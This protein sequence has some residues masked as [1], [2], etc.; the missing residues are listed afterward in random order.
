MS[1]N[2]IESADEGFD[3][4]ERLKNERKFMLEY[5]DHN[6]KK[7]KKEKLNDHKVSIIFKL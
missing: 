5:M 1:K 2:N 6:K 4:L 7:N 3:E